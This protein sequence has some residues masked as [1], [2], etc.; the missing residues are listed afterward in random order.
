MPLLMTW[1]RFAAPMFCA[2]ILTAAPPKIMLWSWYA[3]DDFRF[4]KNSGI[5]VAYLA[6]S[7]QLAGRDEVTPNPRAIPVR[8]APGTWQTAVVRIDFDAYGTRRPAFTAQQSK[9]AAR[10]IAEIAQ[11]SQANAIQ[12]DF[13]APETAYPFYRGLLADVRGRLGPKMFLS[14][15]ALVSW[16][17]T[18]ESWLAGLP[19]DEIVPMAFQMGLS[20]PAILTMLQGG[21][22]FNFA[23]CRGSIGVQLQEEASVRPRKDQRV[24][25]FAH[26]SWSPQDVRAAQA[27]ILP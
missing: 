25:F 18:Q 2:V 26:Y 23:A 17:L 21:G 24:Y 22:Q 4:L 20:T 14:V 13:D 15:T 27:M 11:I 3:D 16:C 12:I 19:V 1:V 10:M 6:L 8:I 7:L 5:G 9:L